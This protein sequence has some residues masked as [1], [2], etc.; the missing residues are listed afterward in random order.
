[1]N[2]NSLTFTDL[3]VLSEEASELVVAIYP[4]AKEIQHQGEISE[5]R[6]LPSL[7]L[8]GIRWVLKLRSGTHPSMVHRAILLNVILL[9]LF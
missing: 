4:S 1:M 3:Q 7:E 8:L 2:F 5:M 9:I 6:A